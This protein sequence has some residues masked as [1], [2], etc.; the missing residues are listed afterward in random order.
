MYRNQVREMKTEIK[1]Y[2]AWQ[3]GS[4]GNCVGWLLI[5]IQAS[6]PEDLSNIL[7][8]PGETD[9]AGTRAQTGETNHPCHSAAFSSGQELGK[10]HRI[11][12]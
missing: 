6:T 1:M 5:Q 10:N 4:V 12:A 3:T 9:A 8:T 2:F 7:L 11:S